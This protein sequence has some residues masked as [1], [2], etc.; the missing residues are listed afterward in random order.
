MII[1]I[2]ASLIKKMM[3]NLLRLPAEWEPQ[4]GV[5]LTWPHAETDWRP[6]LDEI[7]ETYLQL[8]EAI[9]RRE[10]LLIIAPDTDAVRTLLQSR[11]DA[12]CMAN[13]RLCRCQTNDTWAR[14]YHACGQRR[15]A[16]SRFSFQRL[17]REIRL[18]TRQCHHAPALRAKSVARTAHRP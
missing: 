7:T 2:F 1:T 16:D 6:Y 8:A 18:H 9:A 4:S 17:G 12:A 3:T 5:Q 11:L 14:R 13:I 15:G 10:L